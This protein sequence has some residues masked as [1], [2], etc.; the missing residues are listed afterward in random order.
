MMD[1]PSIDVCRAIIMPKVTSLADQTLM[2]QRAP[3]PISKLDPLKLECPGGKALRGEVALATLRRE[4]QEECGLTV[5]RIIRGPYDYSRPAV[6]LDALKTIY[7]VQHFLVEVEPFTL[8]DVRLSD[9]HVDA[10]MVSL[11]EIVKARFQ[12]LDALM[13]PNF[14]FRNSAIRSLVDFAQDIGLLPTPQAL[15]PELFPEHTP[16]RSQ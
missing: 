11:E 15:H 12:P 5:I 9:E 6:I 10:K 13:S 8:A 4:V 3:E 14:P 16:P 7:Q 1:S 2:L